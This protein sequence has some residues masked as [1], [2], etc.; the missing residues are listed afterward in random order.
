MVTSSICC[1]VTLL[2]VRGQINNFEKVPHFV[3]LHQSHL[4]N[5]SHIRSYQKNDGGSIEMTD[6]SSI[7][8]S[9]A[10]KDQILALIRKFS[11]I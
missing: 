2:W 11:S 7:P 6:G 8:I 10:K 1:N 3:R 4:I 5:T 9:R